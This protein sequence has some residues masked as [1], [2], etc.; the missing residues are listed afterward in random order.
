M[1]IPDHVRPQFT[2]NLIGGLAMHLVGSFPAR[3]AFHVFVVVVGTL[4]LA[5]AVN[6]AIVGSN[7]VLNRV[8]ED[9]VLTDWFRHPHPRFG[10][11]HRLINLVVLFQIITIVASR[12]DVTFLGNLYAFGVIWSFSMKGIAVLVLRYTHP[13][14]REYRV[15]LNPVIFGKEIPIGLGIITLV[16]FSI[17]VINLFTKP[18][19]TIAGLTFSAL[20]FTVFEISEYRMHKRQAGAAH[21][22]LD[23]FNL[24][25]EAEL[26]PT[27]LGVR[28]GNIIV[29]VSNYY[30]L[31]H[32]EAALRRPTD[33]ADIVVLHMRI[34]R[35]AASGEYDLAPDQLF[36]TIEQL[37]FTKVLSI[38]EKEGKPVRLAVA[39]AN[40]LWEGVLRT[41]ANLQSRTIVAGSSS[42]MPVT[43]QAREIGLAWERMP[44]PRPSVTLEI[45]TP[46]G[47]EQ[48]FYLGPH[49]PRLT[50]KEI[51]L[52]HKLWLDLSDKLPGEEV[53]HH[54]IV[55]F[56][57]A[58]VERE[59]AQGQGDA[60]LERM[61]EHL[62]EISTR[63]RNPEQGS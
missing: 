42:K 14:D 58:E 20:L 55:H 26:T 16:L 35:R 5:G 30:A 47:Q 41:A 56:A 49:A 6:T 22:E 46:S 33:G 38:A 44:E 15:P 13:Q 62:Q 52:L 3:L 25:Q 54:D 27:S 11:T 60:V 8:S 36:S 40:D 53:H 43:E 61:R 24:A 21:V 9:G 12:G 34:L 48:I 32:L 51:D 63:R 31:Y 17:A 28:T 59:I 7:G 23:Q 39:A 50:P 29:P 37:L 19:A 45:F 18:Q 2:E 1:I 4:I 10:T 57:L